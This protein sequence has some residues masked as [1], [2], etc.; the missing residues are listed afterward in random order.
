MAGSIGSVVCSRVI[1]HARPQA[2]RVQT[3]QIPGVN[4]YGVHLLG[5]GNSE[6]QF[7]AIAYGRDTVVSGVIHLPTWY[8]SLRDT[9]GTIITIT[10][11]QGIAFADQLVLEVGD[12]QRQTAN[13]LN[14][15]TA[16]FQVNI[17]TVTV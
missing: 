15:I 12:P 10:N 3:W 7:A 16:R 1:G 6:S 8:A 13:D 11:E 14:N 17:R 9:Q 5:D 2:T 4:G